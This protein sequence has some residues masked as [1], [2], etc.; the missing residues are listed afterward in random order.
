MANAL[1]GP[2]TFDEMRHASYTGPSEISVHKQ[3][4]KEWKLKE[5]AFY[6]GNNVD[7]VS[8]EGKI[9]AL[10][11][12]TAKRVERAGKDGGADRVGFFIGLI[13]PLGNIIKTNSEAVANSL[14]TIR[15]V[16]ET[17]PFSPPVFVKF[18]KLKAAGGGTAHQIMFI[19]DNELDPKEFYDDYTKFLP[20][21]RG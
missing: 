20:S 1:I 11:G 16:M 4:G 18:M 21:K 8:N 6:T 12:W 7:L 10:E 5:L 14:D 17:A 19:P 9:F 13:D 2:P 3:T 15:R